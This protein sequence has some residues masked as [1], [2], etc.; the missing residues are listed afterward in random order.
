ME[1][2]PPSSK[3][4]YHSPRRAAQKSATRRR[5]LDTLAEHLGAG[6]FDSLSMDAI[7]GAAGVSP[8]TLYRYFP[9]REALL[10]AFADE[11][12]FQRLGDL[13]Y[14][15]TPEEIAP[16]MARSF[17]TFDRDVA[18]VRA[19]FSTEL[20]RTARTR[21]RRRRVESIQAALRPLTSRL[22]EEER[23]A[24]EAIISYLAS[25]QA[26]V[27]IQDEFG[28]TG[29]QVG[30]AVTWAIETLLAELEARPQPGAAIAEP[31]GA[32]DDR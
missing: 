25:I 16:I 12:M 1:P 2:S 29:A 15:H 28:L 18:F 17:E 23:A 4:P 22:S 9:S 27:T 11:T 24:A 6:T 32:H 20:G 26:W 21:G 14:P 31:K 19:Y 7:A 3:R 5:I 13:P 30:R 10:D 8:A